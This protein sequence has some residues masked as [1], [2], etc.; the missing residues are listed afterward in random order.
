MSA[1]LEHLLSPI[2]HW[3]DD[4]AVEDVCIQDTTS[5]WVYARGSFTHHPIDVDPFWAEDLAIVAAA[6]R[7]QDIS[8]SRPL[9]DTGLPGRESRRLSAIVHPCVAEGR[10]ALTFRRGSK[11]WPTLEGLDQSGLFRNTVAAKERVKDETLLG[12]YREKQW[13][14]FL[15]EAV[16]RKKT[17]IVCGENSAGKTHISKAL[18]DA[19]P[20]QERLIAIEDS[21]EL[22]GIPHPNSVTLYY[23]KNGDGVSPSH[24]VQAALRMRI[25]RLFL[26]EIRDGAGAAA[27]LETLQTGHSGGITTIHAPDCK[28]L[29]PRL[30]FV[31]KQTPW[32]AAMEDIDIDAQFRTLVDIAVHPVRLQDGEFGVGGIWFSDC[33][34]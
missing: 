12:L 21:P 30:R 2:A 9:L 24:L 7:R 5:A 34:D 1:T 11:E 13:K 23:D 33:E 17:I 26:Q 15:A 8:A 20:R 19:I 32:G 29:F 28:G 18:L 25:G 27:F 4:D 3:L 22:I 31:I 6:R 10:V 14:T 16:R